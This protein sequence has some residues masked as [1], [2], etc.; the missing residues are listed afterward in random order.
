M[1]IVLGL[2][3]YEASD[4]SALFPFLLC[5]LTR[6]TL[7]VFKAL[8][9]GEWNA[10]HLHVQNALSFCGLLWGI[11]AGK[12]GACLVFQRPKIP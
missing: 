10:S 1:R 12:R 7:T 4:A 6:S 8:W 3:A 2:D 5:P 11:S 9:G